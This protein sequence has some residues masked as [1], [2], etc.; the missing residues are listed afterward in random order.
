MKFKSTFVTDIPPVKG[1]KPLNG[2][3]YSEGSVVFI[4][5][6]GGYFIYNEYGN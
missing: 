4:F 2:V 5:D 1:I 3:R 6:T